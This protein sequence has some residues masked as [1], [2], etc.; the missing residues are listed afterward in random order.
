MLGFPKDFEENVSM[1]SAVRAFKVSRQK[2]R[3]PLSAK[4][5]LAFGEIEKKL[6]ITL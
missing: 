6:I 3:H 2:R 5:S 4:Q 1:A